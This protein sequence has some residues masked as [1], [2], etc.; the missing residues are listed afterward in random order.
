MQAAL[1]ASQATRTG[2][3]VHLIP[4]ELITVPDC[5]TPSICC[6]ASSTTCPAQLLSVLCICRRAAA[7]PAYALQQQQQQQ[8]RRSQAAASDSPDLVPTWSE[9]SSS[10]Q[11]GS[12]SLPPYSQ[13]R[14]CVGC[15]VGCI[16]AGL[17]STASQLCMFQLPV[18][19]LIM[20]PSVCS[21]CVT[22]G[23]ARAAPGTG[24]TVPVPGLCQLPGPAA[25]LGFPDS[26]IQRQLAVRW[27]LLS[28]LAALMQSS[29]SHFHVCQA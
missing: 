5:C 23:G 2:E 15:C 9:S 6:S 28:Q 22:A 13:V 3:P 25:A 12:S 11:P 10:S 14:C 16:A 27:L 19:A 1:R 7:V 29:C 24:R 20:C 4:W 17:L 8:Q 26:A 21:L 18:S